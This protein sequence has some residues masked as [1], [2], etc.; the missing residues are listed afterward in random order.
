MSR[1]EII[2][3]EHLLL[4][5]HNI[6]QGNLSAD[7][8]RSGISDFPVV[9]Q[10]IMLHRYVL[11]LIIESNHLFFRIHNRMDAERHNTARHGMSDVQIK[12]N[13]ELRPV[14]DLS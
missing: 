14:N 9:N 11:L 3:C 1:R 4:L 12:D 7:G 6:D 13:R 5:C 2:V 10:K 8:Q